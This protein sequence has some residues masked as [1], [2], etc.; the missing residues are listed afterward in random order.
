MH[1][2]E[3]VDSDVGRQSW[4]QSPLL[5]LHGLV[6]SCSREGEGRQRERVSGPPWDFSVRI[7]LLRDRIVTTFTLDLEGVTTQP[8]FQAVCPPGPQSCAQ[9]SCKPISCLRIRKRS[10]FAWRAEPHFHSRSLTCL[11]VPAA[12]PGHS[13]DLSEP[14]P[15]TPA[16]RPLPH[17]AGCSRHRPSCASPGWCCSAGPRTP[18]RQPCCTCPSSPTPDLPTTACPLGRQ[19]GMKPSKMLFPG[20]PEGPALPGWAGF[21]QA[22]PHLPS[23][24]PSWP[25]L[26]LSLLP[27]SSPHP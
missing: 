4:E 1:M 10:P 27:P 15:A 26:L 17:P 6:P 8:S 16:P 23:I 7:M 22:S 20:F 25:A 24:S 14:H 18:S 13:P 19:E 21:P 5:T 2:Q 9:G 3:R 12:N 11:G